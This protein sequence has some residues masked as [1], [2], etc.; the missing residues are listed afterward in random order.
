M[1]CSL[2][3]ESPLGDSIS[4]LSGRLQAVKKEVSDFPKVAAQVREAKQGNAQRDTKRLK[5]QLEEQKKLKTSLLTVRTTAEI[6]SEEFQEAN[7]AFREKIYDIWKGSLSHLLP[8]VPQQ[9]P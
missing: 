1:P 6:S 5:S 7:A 4:G 8:V 3:V 2:S 9:I